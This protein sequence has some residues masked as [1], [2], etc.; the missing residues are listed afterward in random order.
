MVYI[1][2]VL[3]NFA[4]NSF[5]DY[6]ISF[7]VLIIT[8]ILLFLFKL[9]LIKKL[10][11]IA[12][13]TKTNIDNT[14]IKSIEGI[15]LHFYILIGIFF[16]IKFISIHEII[17][18][19]V[20]YFIII[21]SAYY[22]IKLLE[23]FLD[24]KIQKISIQKQHEKDDY[25]SYIIRVIG[26]SIKFSIWIMVF[27]I[28]FSN[29]G[30]DITTIVAGLGISGLAIVFALQSVLSDIFASISIYFDK[31]FRVGDFIIVG[32]HMGSVKKIGIKST[33]IETLQGEELVISNKELTETR[34]RNFRNMEK[35]RIEFIIAVTY[36]T[37]VI[38]LKKIPEIIQ[39]IFAKIENAQLQRVHFK[40]FASSSLNYEIVYYVKKPDYKT[41]MDTQQEINFAIKEKF[42][43]ENI[44]MAFPTKTIYLHKK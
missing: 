3:S 41:Y 11:K 28:V 26:S 39:K 43:K 42:E 31:P 10:K 7:G 16:A 29:F 20:F 32:E 35:R 23:N 18:E 8:I 1:K 2:E 13:K 37:K 22:F 4:N 12:E 5:Q 9:L 38:K 6:T 36:D 14:I 40:E 19:F 27:L 17:H 21:N 44:E 34:V 30:Y 33:R 24:S 25:S 15:Q